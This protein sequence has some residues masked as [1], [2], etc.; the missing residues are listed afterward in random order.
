MNNSNQ[1][2]SQFGKVSLIAAGALAATAL[3]A[4][5]QAAIVSV[6]LNETVDP[7][8]V[9][10]GAT[11]VTIHGDTFTVWNQYSIFGTDSANNTLFTSSVQ[12]N[13]LFVSGPV[14]AGTLVG[15]ATDFSFTS[16]SIDHTNPSITKCAFLTTCG[17]FDTPANTNL[18]NVFIPIEFLTLS[19]F[20]Y[21]FL[22]LDITFNGNN[23]PYTVVLEGYS[24][25]NT[26]RPIRTADIPE[27]NT[28]LLL[29]AGAI[30]LA[31]LRKKKQA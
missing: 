8:A 17:S 11:P 27:P 24:Y 26:G 21:G 29:G 10:G 31:A 3:A 4:P 1:K 16:G 12:A 15:P 5:A 19:G 6:V 20:D 22:D 23:K 14:G 30:G 25:D 13:G 7:S 28:L 18:G 2:A 9:A